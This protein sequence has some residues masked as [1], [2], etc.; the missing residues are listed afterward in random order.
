MNTSFKIETL[1]HV[2]MFTYNQ[3]T[4]IVPMSIV[5]V[6]V[7]TCGEWSVFVYI[8]SLLV[9]PGVEMTLISP[10]IYYN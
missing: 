4:A 10:V 8:N 5:L 6:H 9:T 1:I 7:L 2:C 3:L